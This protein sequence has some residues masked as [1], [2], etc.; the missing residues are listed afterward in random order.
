MLWG[1]SGVPHDPITN[2]E[3]IVFIIEA[4]A[5]TF[6]N[7]IFLVGPSFVVNPKGAPWGTGGRGLTPMVFLL[8]MH[9][10]LLFGEPSFSLPKKMSLIRAG[11]FLMPIII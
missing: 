6:V 11:K 10:S 4:Y 2:P 9:Q 3:G 1:S 7:N 8:V 5:T